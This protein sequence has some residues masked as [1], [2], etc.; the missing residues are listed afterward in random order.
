MYPHNQSLQPVR[1]IS[2]FNQNSRQVFLPHCAFL[3]IR[4]SNPFEVRDDIPW[5]AESFFQA[6]PAFWL[7]SI[8]F[9]CRSLHVLQPVEHQILNI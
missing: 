2:C 4:S 9:L 6:I 3:D 5:A 8:E 1:L 7:F